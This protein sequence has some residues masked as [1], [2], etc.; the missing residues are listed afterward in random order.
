MKPETEYLTVTE[1]SDKLLE[2]I[3]ANKGHYTIDVDGY[4]LIEAYEVNDTHRYIK[5]QQYENY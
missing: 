4:Y 3:A 5:L 2:L 1:L